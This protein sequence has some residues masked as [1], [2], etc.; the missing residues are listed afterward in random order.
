MSMDGD[1]RLPWRPSCAIYG[2]YAISS[3][4]SI[5]IPIFKFHSAN[6]TIYSV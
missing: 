5:S 2:A 3:S 4:L 6:S 1:I